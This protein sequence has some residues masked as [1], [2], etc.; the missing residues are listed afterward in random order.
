MSEVKSNR[1]WRLECEELRSRLVEAE[2]AL[3]IVAEQDWRYD[4]LKARLAEAEAQAVRHR[5]RVPG[6][7][8][9]GK[10]PHEGGH[11]PGAADDQPC[12]FCSKD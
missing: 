5:R 4:E 10:R 9:Q 3:R 6:C 1:A 2:T 7:L 8:D 11:G 12:P